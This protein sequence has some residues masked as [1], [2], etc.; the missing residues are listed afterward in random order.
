M[1]KDKNNPNATVKY[2]ELLEQ[3]MIPF[4]DEFR[5]VEYVEDFLEFA[6]K[7]WNLGNIEALIPIEESEKAIKLIEEG[8]INSVLLRRMIDYKISDFKQ[9][10]NYIVDYELI[11]AKGGEDPILRIVTQKKGSLFN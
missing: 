10:E 5:E 11:E 4:I 2:S 6:I 1:F 7:A 8:E 9:Y 3:F